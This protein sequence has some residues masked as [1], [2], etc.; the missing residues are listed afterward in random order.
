M[1]PSIEIDDAIFQE[2]VNF[3]SNV[4][5]LPPLAAKIHAYLI[6][7]FEKKGVTFDELVEVFCASKSSI[8]TNLNF[9][10]NLNLIQDLTKIDE[11]KRYFVINKDSVKLRFSGI[12]EKLE[13]E[14]KILDALHQFN[15]NKDTLLF[16]R[17]DIYRSL[18]TNSIENIKESLNK[19]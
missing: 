13:K 8:S 18:L 12:V 15:Q 3:Y 17:H 1:K 19:L 9:L 16:K 7:D 2:L 6:F 14:V 11:R 10:L 4:Y 5:Q